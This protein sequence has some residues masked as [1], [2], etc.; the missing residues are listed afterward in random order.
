MILAKPKYLLNAA[1]LGERGNVARYGLARVVG[2]RSG[3][4]SMPDGLISK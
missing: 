3:E 2:L 1:R 4:A